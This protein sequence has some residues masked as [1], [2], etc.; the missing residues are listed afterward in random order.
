ML[1]VNSRISASRCCCI[2]ARQLNINL[3][4][5][6]STAASIQHHADFQ[7]VSSLDVRSQLPQEYTPGHV[8]SVLNQVGKGGKEMAENDF[9]LLLES[10]RPY[11]TRDARVILTAMINYKRINEFLLTKDLAV[12]CIHQILESDP[13]TGAILV[14]EHF[15]PESGLYFAAPREALQKVMLRVLE[16]VDDHSDRIWKA[17]PD[18]VNNLLL[19]QSRPY[20]EMKKR[21]ARKY[22]KQIQVHEGVNEEF[23][24]LLVD[25]G[26]SATNQNVPL[27][28][29]HIVQPCLDHGRVTKIGQDF[30]IS[31]EAKR[32]AYIP[33][34]D[35]A[36]DDLT[37]FEPLSNKEAS[38]RPDSK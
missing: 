9:R 1:I 30:V 28:H 35:L 16:G 26:L 38:D 24:N 20:H 33:P 29:E 32:L 18:F 22:L 27:V 21:A 17:L 36:E 37:E 2:L 7:T 11:E 3:L 5:S 12:D 15:T 8:M 25:V 10:A 19:R 14:L 6:A 4:R 31:W 34:D 13:E 23:L